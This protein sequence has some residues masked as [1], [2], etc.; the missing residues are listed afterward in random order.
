MRA[1]TTSLGGQRRRNSATSS[2]SAAQTRTA[3]RSKTPARP[4]RRCPPPEWDR[5]L[6]G[7]GPSFVVGTGHSPNSLGDLCLRRPTLLVSR[8][9]PEMLSASASGK[10]WDFLRPRGPP[11]CT[12]GRHRV[13]PLRETLRCGCRGFKRPSTWDTNVPS[14]RATLPR[15]DFPRPAEHSRRCSPQAYR[16]PRLSL[17]P[18]AAGGTPVRVVARAS[19]RS[20]C[21]IGATPRT[22]EHPT[23][24]E[25]T[26][27]D[28]HLPMPARSSFRWME[29]IDQHPPA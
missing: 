8:G 25:I 2:S 3:A 24:R 22:R 4:L 23:S 5:S 11:A 20:R 18:N 21:G 12:E 1:M 9:V 27:D 28:A 7:F 10:G 6:P 29:R 26:G 17:S 13:S 19:P 16:I 14:R 15:W